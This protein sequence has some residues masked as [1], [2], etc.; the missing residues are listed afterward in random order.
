MEKNQMIPC[1]TNAKLIPVI[2]H[3]HTKQKTEYFELSN[4][5]DC[6]FHYQIQNQSRK[7]NKNSNLSCEKSPFQNYFAKKTKAPQNSRLEIYISQDKKIDNKFENNKLNLNTE[8]KSVKNLNTLPKKLTSDSKI[9]FLQSVN[10]QNAHRNNLKT[11][12]KNRESRMINKNNKSENF[13]NCLTTKTQEFKYVNTNL[14]QHK[15][16]ARKIRNPSEK[17]D[18][19]KMILNKNKKNQ[20]SNP[21]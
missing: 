17:D 21:S 9:L 14:H 3:N 5:T 11:S 20:K 12:S 15:E 2:E 4:P 6:S 7:K 13:S 10:T 8:V 18:N 1:N 16:T 19:S